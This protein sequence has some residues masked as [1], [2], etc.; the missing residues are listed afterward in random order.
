LQ[1]DNE[2]IAKMYQLVSNVREGKSVLTSEEVSA[3]YR[4]WE[5]RKLEDKAEQQAKKGW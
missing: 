3:P 1:E 2:R 5:Q 4:A